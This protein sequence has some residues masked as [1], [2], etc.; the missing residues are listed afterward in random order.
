[1][2]LTLKDFVREALTQILLGIDE[3]KD[4][5]AKHDR[6]R[7]MVS[8]QIYR[9]GAGQTVHDTDVMVYWDPKTM[10][11]AHLVQFDVAVHASTTDDSQAEGGLG[12][13][14][15]TMFSAKAAGKVQ[16]TSQEGNISRIQFAI[17][18]IMS[19]SVT[20]EPIPEKE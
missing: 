12:I 11:K 18:I 4:V 14:V 2:S 17:P 3:A 10:V 5:I 9:V 6:D 20:P 15:A 16:Q 1:M 8:P 13:Q 7:R 19:E